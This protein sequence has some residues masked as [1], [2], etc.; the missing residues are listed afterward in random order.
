MSK[1]TTN[2]RCIC[3]S[4]LLCCAFALCGEW[5]CAAPSTDGQS[6]VKLASLGLR[7]DEIISMDQL[8]E[9]VLRRE[10]V[11]IFDARSK[12]SY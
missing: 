7:P 11:L 6:G 4:L 12:R 1:I 10:P 9:K 3:L 8:K 5:L 2:R